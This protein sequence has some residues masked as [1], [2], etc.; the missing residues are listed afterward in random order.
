MESRPSPP[1]GALYHERIDLE[2]LAAARRLLSGVEWRLH[3]I[4]REEG[5]PTPFGL[6]RYL[7]L[8]ELERATEYGLPARRLAGL[9]DLRP[10]TVA[11]HLDVLERA[12]F[13]HRAPWTLYDRRR[14]AVRLTPTGRYAVRRFTGA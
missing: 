6:T 14:V 13:V 9:L 12:G 8:V 5:W 4:A 10:S 11:H 7:I 2:A 1:P 3:R